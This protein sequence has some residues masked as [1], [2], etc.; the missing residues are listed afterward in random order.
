MNEQD[1]KMQK[2][3]EEAVYTPC[4]SAPVK[5]DPVTFLGNNFPEITSPEANCAFSANRL[6]I[7]LNWSYKDF[8]PGDFWRIAALY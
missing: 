6:K 5:C 8:I 1:S 3:S 4:S 2:T 7:L